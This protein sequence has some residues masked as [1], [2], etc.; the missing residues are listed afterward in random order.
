MLSGNEAITVDIKAENDAEMRALYS[1]GTVDDPLSQWEGLDRE[2]AVYIYQ[3]DGNIVD[4]WKE[5]DD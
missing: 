4:I 1:D 2:E 5:K 3:V